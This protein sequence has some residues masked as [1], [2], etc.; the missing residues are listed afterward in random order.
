MRRPAVEATGPAQGETVFAVQT[1]STKVTGLIN[2]VVVDSHSTQ[3]GNVW[4]VGYAYGKVAN[5]QTDI[6][7]STADDAPEQEITVQTDGRNRLTVWFG[8]RPVFSSDQLDMD[9]EAP[10]QPYLEVQ[11]LH[12]ASV[13]NFTDY[14][15]TSSDS[16]GVEGVPPSAQVCL[17]QSGGAVPICST[18]AG[19]AATLRLPP[20]YCNG[21]GVLSV[22]S[23]E[24]LPVQFTGVGY[25]CGS[26]YRVGGV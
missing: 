3:D 15:I 19:S 23:S 11:A 22:R 24:R 14:W 26:R 10:F 16:V 1:A 25:S 2:Y 8:D 18:A 5:A 13:A 7:W 4:E 21:E 12:T 6:Y 9:I 20:P 17:T